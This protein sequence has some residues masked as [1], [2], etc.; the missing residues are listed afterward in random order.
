MINKTLARDASLSLK[1]AIRCEFC[2][3]FGFGFVYATFLSRI[4]GIR[5]LM[6]DLDPTQA[7]LLL[8][9]CSAGSV[10]MAPIAGSILERFSIRKV[11]RVSIVAAAFFLITL[12]FVALTGVLWLAVANTFCLGISFSLYNVGV[13][14]SGVAIEKRSKGRSL[15]PR[16]HSFFQIGAVVGTTWSQVVIFTGL[17]LQVQT[18]AVGIVVIALVFISVRGVYSTAN[19]ASHKDVISADLGGSIEGAGFTVIPEEPRYKGKGRPDGV[20]AKFWGKGVD[21][22]VLIIGLMALSS[23]LCEGSGNDWISGGLVEGFG[24][25]EWFGIMGMW[26]YL[27]TTAVTRFFGTHLLDRFGRA[28]VMRGCF[29]CAFIGIAL[30]IFS[31]LVPLAFIGCFIWGIGV[32]LGYPVAISAASEGER[33]SAFRASIVATL[34]NTMNIAGPP[35]IGLLAT[36][37][38]IRFALVIL[39]PFTIIGFLCTK[40]LK[41]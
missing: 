23:T 9:G 14:V 34:G 5:E 38:S 37:I 12:S 15:M 7:S 6:G 17:G 11:C 3:F 28:I 30:Y 36:S 40:V 32:S 22:T 31:P 8:L 19:V 20:R 21:S 35:L 10:M 1:K 18:I 26:V 16:F 13:N 41:K 39:I 27:I 33:K 24:Q 2:L 29:A 4:V 25:P